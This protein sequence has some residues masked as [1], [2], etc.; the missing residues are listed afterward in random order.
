MD[1]ILDKRI[2]RK[3]V[4]CLVRR[5]GW[6]PQDA[7][8]EG[9]TSFSRA[10]SRAA[11]GAPFLPCTTNARSRISFAA[12]LDGTSGAT[13]MTQPFN[14]LYLTLKEMAWTYIGPRRSPYANMLE[15]QKSLMYYTCTSAIATS[16]S[17][18]TS[19]STVCLQPPHSSSPSQV[20]LVLSK[21]PTTTPNHR[22]TSPE[23]VP[24]S[25]FDTTS[26]T[27]SLPSTVRLRKKN[28]RVLVND[29]SLP[30]C[31]AGRH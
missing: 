2:R 28:L 16:T 27:Q 5:L 21:S 19:P 30:G 20:P 8:S 17:Y 12:S 10:G 1:E 18:A 14:T 22:A 24:I 31:C 23:P 29:P 25:H 9:G 4:E 11:S 13:M 7:P 3:K 6:G 15:T 26:V